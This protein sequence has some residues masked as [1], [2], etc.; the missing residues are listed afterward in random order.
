MSARLPQDGARGRIA[1][2]ISQEGAPSSRRDR[3]HCESRHDQT[4]I[5][6]PG[7]A[8]GLQGGTAREH[9]ISFPI[10]STVRAAC[11]GAPNRRA[12]A[13]PRNKAMGPGTAAP[14]GRLVDGQRTG[15]PAS[16]SP[17]GVHP[18]LDI[19]RR[20]AIRL[21]LRR[22]IAKKVS[23]LARIMRGRRRVIAAL[24]LTLRMS[25]HLRL[26]TFPRCL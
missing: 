2:A 14:F 15:Q 10:R 18:P 22:T 4:R 6:P 13:K 11:S 17:S 9:I 8:K 7:P 16:C 20:A 25:A 3:P 24:Q 21:H 26:N 23:S 1:S 19:R 12:N 5:T